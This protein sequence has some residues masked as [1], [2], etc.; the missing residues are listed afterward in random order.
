V[1]SSRSPHLQVFFAEGLP[2]WP[3]RREVGRQQRVCGR[4]PLNTVD[5][6]QNTREFCPHLR[7]RAMTGMGTIVFDDPTS[8]GVNQLCLINQRSFCCA[9]NTRWARG[10]AQSR[11]GTDYSRVCMHGICTVQLQAPLTSGLASVD[12]SQ[13]AAPPLRA[14]AAYVGDTVVT[15]TF[16][17]RHQ[18]S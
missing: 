3:G 12:L 1:L 5:A 11:I 9:D 16:S 6:V 15:C 18:P 14:S 8:T 4:V 10:A 2:S 7:A 13:P 17:S